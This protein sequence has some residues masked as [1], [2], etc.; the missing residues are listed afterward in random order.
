[1]LDM[2]LATTVRLSLHANINGYS[3][4]RLPKTQLYSL[5][6]DRR[7]LTSETVIA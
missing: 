1:M 6:I 5:T 4:A 7:R 3:G 2:K